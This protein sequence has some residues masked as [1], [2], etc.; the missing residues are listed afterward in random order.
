M[1]GT[2]S[3]RTGPSRP[4][5]SASG[6]LGRL[7]QAWAPLVRT[8]E[9]PTPPPGQSSAQPGPCPAQPGPLP[10]TAHEGIPE[11][12]KGLCWPGPTSI[13]AKETVAWGGGGYWHHTCPDAPGPQPAGARLPPGAACGMQ[14]AAGYS[15]SWWSLHPR[16]SSYAVC[17]AVS[18]PL[19]GLPLLQLR[20]GPGGSGKPL[21][22]LGPRGR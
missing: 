19:L 14:L 12:R 22:T 20:I 10:S 1:A 7:H 9:G 3:V 18:L 11:H 15:P 13:S 2:G 16:Q 5:R 4:L 8:P 6:L 17:P 21:R